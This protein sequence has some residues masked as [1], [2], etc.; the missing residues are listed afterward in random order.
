[1]STNLLVLKDKVQR[2]LTSEFNRVEL[3]KDGGFTLRHE[4]ARMFIRCWEGDQKTFVRLTCPIVFDVQPSA[5]LFEHVAKTGGHYI[6]GNVFVG[7]ASDGSVTLLMQHTLLGDYLD[8]QELIQ[9]V[10]AML[11]SANEIDDELAARFGGR[12]FHEN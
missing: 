2:I 3:D 12:V 6:F 1:M 7:E 11:G 10:I 4:S 8:D 9:A 5:E